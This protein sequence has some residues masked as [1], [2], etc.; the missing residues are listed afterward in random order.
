V[1]RLRRSVEAASARQ[2]EHREAMVRL[3]AEMLRR[4]LDEGQ[5]RTVVLDPPQANDN[6]RDP[7]EPPTKA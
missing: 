6:S 7:E 3:A 1:E 4:A 2:I 5:G